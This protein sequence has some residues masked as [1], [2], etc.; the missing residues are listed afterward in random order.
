VKRAG[1]YPVAL[2]GAFVATS[3]VVVGVSV[4]T[5]WHDPTNV[6]V[7]FAHRP[8]LDGWVRWDAAWY[9]EIARHGYHY[10]GPHLQSSVAF[11]PMYP[12]LMRFLGG[13]LGDDALAGIVVSAISGLVVAV[14]FFRWCEQRLGTATARLALAAMLTY[15][16]AF[17]LFGAVYADALFIAAALAAFALLEADHPVLAGAAGAVATASRPVGAALV[18]GLVVRT[19]E[20]RGALPGSSFGR[21]GPADADR[22]PAGGA[23]LTAAPSSTRIASPTRRLGRKRLEPRDAGVLLSLAGLIGYCVM[24]A[25]RFG[26]PLAF[27]SVA[28]APGWQQAPGPRV[29]LK[30]AVFSRASHFPFGFSDYTIFAQALLTAVALALVPRVIRRLGWG[31]GAFTAA[32]IVLPALST[33]DFAGMGRYLLAAFPCFALIGEHLR[34]RRREAAVYLAGSGALLVLCTVLFSRSYYVS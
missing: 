26:D 25:I 7:A 6:S 14:L 1:W 3:F 29:W 13:P 18:I 8:W 30:F 22:E 31:Y 16:F 23:T 28:G 9:L 33:K 24:L 27:E 12:L 21:Q 20:L 11:F 2:L 17:Y 34:A 4:G 32:I 19:L 15:P 10:R 5:W